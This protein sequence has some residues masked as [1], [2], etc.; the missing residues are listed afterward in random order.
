MFRLFSRVRCPY[1]FDEFR[2]REAEY[3]CTS[4]ACDQ[5]LD[6]VLAARWDNPFPT[7]R[8]FASKARKNPVCP[9]CGTSSA[10]QICPACHHTL[11]L[12]LSGTRSLTY[13]VVGSRF[14]GAS[15][16]L[17][18]ALHE[19]QHSVC[20]DLDAVVQP[21]DDVS[22]QRWKGEY[23]DALYRY[24]RVPAATRLG[25]SELR[26]PLSFS[27]A[28][29]QGTNR[30]V[31]S[32]LHFHDPAGQE[33]TAY[34]SG[35]PVA[36]YLGAADGIVFILDPLG[37]PTLRASLD[38]RSLGMNSL[39]VPS[40]W[41]SL[42]GIVR[43]ME[44][45]RKTSFETKI[46]TPMAVVVS[47]F[48]LVMPHVPRDLSLLKE[49]RHTRGFDRRGFEETQGEIMELL[50]SWNAADLLHFMSTRFRSVGFFVAAAFGQ[51]PSGGGATVNAK[52]HRVV[53]PLL[54]LLAGNGVVNN[55]RNP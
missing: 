44:K 42:M 7:G 48:D 22:S 27:M 28:I 47:K 32:Y 54:W 9:D 2:L 14:A 20:S 36:S 35:E 45:I 41:D 52:P 16:W 1:C 53:D 5:T 51:S 4:A 18:V 43:M 55:A 40:P 33:F 31:P 6:P 11:P 15:T 21:L 46:C 49:S 26:S 30:F 29:R 17:G 24:S 25:C 37:L 38:P 8:T 13:P 19:L 12:D 3:R 50:R 23:E 34:E 10:Q 39:P